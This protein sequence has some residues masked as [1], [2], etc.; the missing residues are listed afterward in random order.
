[1]RSTVLFRFVKTNTAVNSV[2]SCGR[3]KRYAE[4]SKSRYKSLVRRPDGQRPR[5]QEEDSTS[6]DSYLIYLIMKL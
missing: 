3:Q 5:R 6:C 1:M 2:K 4:R